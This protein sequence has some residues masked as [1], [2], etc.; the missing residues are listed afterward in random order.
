MCARRALEWMCEGHLRD[1]R[2][3]F[4]GRPSDVRLMS[5]A[6]S[7][8]QRR[9]FLRKRHRECQLCRA[10]FEEKVKLLFEAFDFN[11]GGSLSKTELTMMITS[12]VCGLIALTGQNE[13]AEPDLKYFEDIIDEAFQK[14]DR[15]QSG[16]VSFEEFIIW[17]R[18]NRDIMVTDHLCT[19]ICI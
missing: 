1:A 7:Q 10:S 18:S 2:R 19:V 4:D 5:A 9:S 6:E 15:D 11:L 16:S 3:A 12:C 17:A 8:A 14:A 13:D